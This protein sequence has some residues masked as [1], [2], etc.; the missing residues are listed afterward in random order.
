MTGVQTC[1]LPIFLPYLNGGILLRAGLAFLMMHGVWAT[2]FT[3]IS[4]LIPHKEIGSI[5]NIAL[6][7]A[8]MFGCY[9]LEFALGQPAYIQETSV[10]TIRM[11]PEEVA[12]V[13]AGTFEGSYAWEEDDAG[14]LT[15]YKTVELR[16]EKRPNPGYVSGGLRTAIE[17]IDNTLPHGQINQYV[18]YLQS[19]L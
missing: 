3:I 1:A 18:C 2:L 4:I 7:I 14:V 19:C 12:Q 17:I 16:G 11:T 5:L 15:Y 9:Q 10:E 8:V 13:N 6:I